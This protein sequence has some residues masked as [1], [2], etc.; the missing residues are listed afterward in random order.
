M[1][2]LVPSM[3]FS[4][5]PQVQAAGQSDPVDASTGSDAAGP[6]V[7]AEAVPKTEVG[8]S[9]DSA[10]VDSMGG[11]SAEQAKALCPEPLVSDADSKAAIEAVTGYLNDL[12]SGGF[13][14]APS[15]LHPVALERFKSLVMP[16]F[17]AERR[18]G[19]RRLLNATFGRD[20]NFVVVQASDPADFM[21]RFVRVI[22]AREPDAAPSF[23]QLEALGVVRE[24][25]Q[26]HVL[27]RLGTGSGSDLVER[28]E[29]LSVLPLGS[30]WK[31]L[32]DGRLE[33][34]AQSLA[35]RSSLNERR[36]GLR[37][38]E[39]VP[40]GAPVLAPPLQGPAGLPQLP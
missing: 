35:N 29:V 2:I 16:A 38:M 10:A 4:A 13:G 8:Q 26:L 18:R 25:D 11:T 27:I 34:V 19:S 20:S 17:E 23:S 6:M 14:A 9:V 32:L 21:G 31:V 39:P 12:K 15:H 24:E 22:T 37:R 30:E 1:A 40:E 36:A 3:G 33:D 7:G 5:E 28:V